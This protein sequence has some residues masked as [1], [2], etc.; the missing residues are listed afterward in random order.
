MEK[1]LVI[2]GSSYLGRSL[3]QGRFS[4]RII[5]TYS[6]NW[7][8]GG[9]RFDVLKDDPSVVFSSILDSVSCVVLLVGDTHPDS[10]RADAV[11]SDA[12]N[13]KAIVRLLEYFLFE[14]K[15]IIFTSSEFVYDGDSGN[16]SEM[17]PALPILLY[18]QQK[19]VVERFFAVEFR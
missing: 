15:Y 13:V 3:S 17:D 11:H 14:K 1:I 16:Y 19:L 9:L 4:D 12:L 5:S 8:E 2:G 18:G 6:S 7:I 10:C